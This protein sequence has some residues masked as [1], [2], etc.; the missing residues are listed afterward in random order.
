MPTEGPREEKL[1]I[2]GYLL[3]VDD[4]FPSFSVAVAPDFLAYFLTAGP[5]GTFRWTVG[6]AWV[7]PSVEFSVRFTSTMPLPPTRLTSADFSTRS[8]TP[9]S[10]TT[11]LPAALA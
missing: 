9:R 10:Q 8:T 11:I 2:C 5:K 7:S 6:T 1:V 4:R 3:G